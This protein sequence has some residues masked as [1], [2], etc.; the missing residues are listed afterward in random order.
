M[1]K[2]RD[3]DAALK[4]LTD[5][6][7]ALKENKRRQLGE[8]IVA[9]GADALDTEML[10][11]GLLAIA[12]TND[13]AEKE[14]WRKRGAEFFRG[15]AKSAPRKSGGNTASAAAG[16]GPQRSPGSTARET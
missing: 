15:T 14:R 3:F 7:K 13:T 1:R 16:G 4:T 12:E 5:K 8:L 6:T 9:T 2:P 10:A 11:G